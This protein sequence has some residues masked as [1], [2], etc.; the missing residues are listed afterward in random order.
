MKPHVQQDYDKSVRRLLFAAADRIFQDHLKWRQEQELPL[1]FRISFGDGQ[2][3]EAI[4]DSEKRQL[5]I[6][7]FLF[8]RPRESESYMEALQRTFPDA[9]V[10][11]TGT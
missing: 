8:V 11:E 3:Y 2:V 1:K 9:T 6:G 7:G 4:L 5:S 10:E